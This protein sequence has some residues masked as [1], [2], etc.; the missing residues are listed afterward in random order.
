MFMYFYIYK[1]K[2]H[3]LYI[4]IYIYICCDLIVCC[5]Y[6]EMSYLKKIRC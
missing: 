5:L 4:Y 3:I 1:Y 6:N 2:I